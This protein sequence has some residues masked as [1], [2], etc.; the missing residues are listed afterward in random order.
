MVIVGF[1]FISI[2]KGPSADDALSLDQKSGVSPYL[3]SVRPRSTGNAPQL[4]SK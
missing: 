2:I 3:N 1:S 4:K